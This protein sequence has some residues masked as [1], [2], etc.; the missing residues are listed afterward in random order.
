MASESN[1][2]SRRV[3]MICA[4]FPPSGGAG[5]Q[6]SAKFAKYLS[7][8]GWTPTVW[9]CGPSPDLPR[10]ESL[11]ADLPEDVDVRVHPFGD[12]GRWRGAMNDV[13]AMIRRWLPGNGRISAG[14]QW[15]ADRAA[16]SVVTRLVPDGH[17]PWA[18]SSFA[19][20]RALIMRRSIDVIY[21]T[22]SPASNHLLAWLLQRA[23][24]RPWVSD[25]RDLWTDDCWY[26]R[27]NGPQWLRAADRRLEHRFLRDADAVTT[28]SDAQRQIL[29]A[30][31]PGAGAKF[32]TIPNGFDHEDFARAEQRMPEPNRAATVR[33]R[34]LPN[35]EGVSVGEQ[36]QAASANRPARH[37]GRFVLAH[38]GRFSRERVRPA[39]IE[40]IAQFVRGLGGQSPQ[41]ELRIVGW[42]PAELQDR[43]RQTGIP[44]TANGYVRHDRAIQEML[45]ADVLL[46][47]YPEEPR[48]DT[49]V[50]GKLF[51]YFASGR[52][53]LMIGP[54]N[55]EA[56]RLV[57]TFEAG[58]GA[59]PRA[60]AIGDAL[61]R[62]WNQWRDGRLPSGCR[63]DSLT[64]FTRRHLAGE[65]A[66][67]LERIRTVRRRG[68]QR[69]LVSSPS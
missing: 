58:V 15:R 21:S 38:V 36:T 52:P 47:Q 28:V 6:R 40:G 23:T 60:E 20:L 62:L 4:A 64:Q 68:A 34:F 12:A 19:P 9:T 41:F 69:V 2:V 13:A 55:S 11:L 24:H 30:K 16:L 59:D 63:R 17:V 35:D 33:E 7:E 44:F 48:A 53:V 14:V 67:V 54:P 65:L 61:T 37:D 50:S 29:A 10:D 43:L 3:L 32:L 31:V 5:V 22:F 8:F 57:E 42:M 1:G 51:E 39:M 45:A 66:R 26:P 46:L 18:L 25:Y 56:R 49:A 27:A